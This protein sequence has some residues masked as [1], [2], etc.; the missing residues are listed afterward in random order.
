M[1]EW[2]LP[3]DRPVAR[4]PMPSVRTLIAAATKLAGVLSLA[5]EVFVRSLKRFLQAWHKYRCCMLWSC[6][7]TLPFFTV[8]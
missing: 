7:L 2:D 8:F 6:I 3:N 4:T 5:I 1:V